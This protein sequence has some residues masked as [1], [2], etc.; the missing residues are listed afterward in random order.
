MRAEHVGGTVESRRGDTKRNRTRPDTSRPC[1]CLCRVIFFV[2]VT[3]AAA[4]AAAA[5]WCGYMHV[6]LSDAAAVVGY[7][8][9]GGGRLSCWRRLQTP[10][11]SGVGL[12]NVICA[13]LL[14]F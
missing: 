11:E 8:L 5:V 9:S 6:V 3:A 2:L 13:F 1:R 10:Q 12:V 14:A 7:V 4:A